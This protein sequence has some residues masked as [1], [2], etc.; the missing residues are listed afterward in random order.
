MHEPIYCHAA[1]TIEFQ[2]DWLAVDND[3]VLGTVALDLDP[4]TGLSPSVVGLLVRHDRRRGGVATALL[5]AAEPV[6]QK[7]G[8]DRLYVST[9]VLGELLLRRGWSMFG[10]VKFINGAHGSV[11]V[12]RF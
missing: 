10:E 7:L 8:Y 12:C 9:D 4:A 5:D 2:L 1:T 11:Y 3:E 6:S